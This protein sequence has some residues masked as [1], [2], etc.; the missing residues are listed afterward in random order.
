MQIYYIFVKKLMQIY[1]TIVK[2]RM[3]IYHMYII[4]KKLMQTFADDQLN[5]IVFIYSAD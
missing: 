3:Q 4:V 1:Y 5:Y 2:K